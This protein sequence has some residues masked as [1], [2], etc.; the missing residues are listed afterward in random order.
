[1]RDVAEKM[2][3]LGTLWSCGA[4][5]FRQV[6]GG[7][8]VFGMGQ[9]SLSGFRRVLRKLQKDGHRVSRPLP[10]PPNLGKGAPGR[11]NFRGSAGAWPHAGEG[12]W[13][14]GPGLPGLECVMVIVVGMAGKFW[15]NVYCI[16]LWGR[17]SSE[18]RSPFYIAL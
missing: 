16:V 2:D 15:A 8:A 10:S 18:V 9:P 14:P 5:N 1:M 13:W 3:V 12:S 17:G 6:Q 11:D 7:L 4:P